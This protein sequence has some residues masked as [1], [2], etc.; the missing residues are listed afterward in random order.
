[1][2]KKTT[3]NLV[4]GNLHGDIIK[5]VIKSWAESSM[6]EMINSETK[7][8]LEGMLGVYIPD[9]I[10]QSVKW[11]SNPPLIDKGIIAGSVFFIDENDVER[12][13]DFSVLPTGEIKSEYGE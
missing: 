5:R 8:N 2:S 4:E 12:C 10:D 9:F 6:F 7:D 11:F 13:I 1:M 3:T